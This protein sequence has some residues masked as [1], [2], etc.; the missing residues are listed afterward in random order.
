[1]NQAGVLL[2]A[3]ALYAQAEP[4]YERALAIR[5]KAVYSLARRQAPQKPISAAC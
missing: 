5:E 2:F 1:M 4:L 3:K